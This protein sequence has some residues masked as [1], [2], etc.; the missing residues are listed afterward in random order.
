MSRARL[1]VAALAPLFLMLAAVLVA[2][3]AEARPAAARP[4]VGQCRTT[5]FAQSFSFADTRAPV[6]C[7]R[8]HRMK[9]Y[10]VPNIPAGV[11]Y[12]KITDLRFAQIATQLCQPRFY[13][14]LGGNHS[15]RNQT[16]YTWS[17]FG[18][19]LAQRKA[20]ARWVRCDVSLLATAPGGTSSFVPLQNLSFPL[21]GARPITD[22]TR[23]CLSDATNSYWTVCLR[24]HAARADQTF[25]MTNKALPSQA[26][27]EAAGDTRCPG[28][29]VTRPGLAEWRL[30]NRAITCYTV[31]N[32]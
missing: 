21:V 7:S 6:A 12:V 11:N 19:T 24:A 1:L 4:Q 5:T 15:L 29:R 26:A 14:A 32:A 16:A 9:T 20:G 23:R 30:G 27:V 8:V 28:K 3:P 18:P 22:K 25:V 13:R 17:Y 2:V 31:T 10:A